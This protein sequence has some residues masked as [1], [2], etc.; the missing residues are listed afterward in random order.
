LYIDFDPANEENSLGKYLK[1]IREDKEI[2]LEELAESTRIKIDYLE[3]IEEDKYDELPK[4]P[5]LTLFL[6]SYSEALEIDYV[7]IRDYL[8]SL[9]SAPKPSKAK[10]AASKPAKEKKK[11]EPLKTKTVAE[12]PE[13]A[14]TEN[15]WEMKNYLG[16]I[17]ALVFIA[18]IAVVLI[19]IF[20]G[21][22]RNDDHSEPA[23]IVEHQDT[24]AVIDSAQILR[25]EFLERF[26]SLI[27]SIHPG[28]QQFYNI[29]ADGN[30]INKVF[31][32]PSVYTVSAHDSLTIYCERTDDSR[33]YLNGFRLITD[34][35][36]LAGE[37]PVIF[38]R[39][40][41]IN[42]VDTTDVE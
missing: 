28:S 30:I 7:K 22:S 41:W 6:K 24:I 29:V 21:D 11:P 34:A 4:G 15:G 33:I 5:Y 23:A 35:V 42:F 40:N 19:I 8:E 20:S 17:G 12:K 3:A 2:T 25:A 14:K 27:I 13:R 10:P 38:D 16:L 26:D 39:D 18:F 31:T 37:N 32:P 9:S 36:D 1:S